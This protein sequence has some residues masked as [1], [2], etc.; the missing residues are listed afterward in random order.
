MGAGGT[1]FGKEDLNETSIVTIAL[2]YFHKIC[3][4]FNSIFYRNFVIAIIKNANAY[5]A[6]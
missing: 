1:L 6:S 2:L 5:S 4:M 3:H